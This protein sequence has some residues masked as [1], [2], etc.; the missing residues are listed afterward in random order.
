[1]KAEI[2]VVI[3]LPGDVVVDTFHLQG[4]LLLFRRRSAVVTV[5]K[6]RSD[7]SRR[8]GN[9]ERCQRRHGFW[10]GGRSWFYMER[11]AREGIDNNDCLVV[12]FAKKN[13][14]ILAHHAL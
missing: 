1:V 4:N 12:V 2:A 10:N 13:G 5:E 3:A 14:A 8:A 6:S 9:D 11:D 7:D